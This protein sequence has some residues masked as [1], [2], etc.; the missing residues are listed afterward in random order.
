[1]FLGEEL[2]IPRALDFRV[3]RESW[4]LL[5]LT[6]MGPSLLIVNTDVCQVLCDLVTL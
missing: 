5:D 6:V 3:D 1:M 4:I 2:V